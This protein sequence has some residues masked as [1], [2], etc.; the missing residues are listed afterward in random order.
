MA[1]YLYHITMRKGTTEK[2]LMVNF[3]LGLKCVTPLGDVLKDVPFDF[4]FIYGESDWVRNMEKEYAQI[5]IEA[6]NKPNCQYYICPDAG[7]NLH[8]DNPEAFSNLIIN[9][10]LGLNL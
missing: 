1:D 3:Q 6:R 9:D 10:L 8:M 2:A 5:S 4:S 7:H